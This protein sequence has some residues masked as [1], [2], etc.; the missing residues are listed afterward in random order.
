[1]SQ[2]NVVKQQLE[3]LFENLRKTKAANEQR[4]QRQQVIECDNFEEQRKRYELQQ[5]AITLQ[6]V[7]LAWKRQAD[8][9]LERATILEAAK[10]EEVARGADVVKSKL[11]KVSGKTAVSKRGAFASPN[12]VGAN[13]AMKKVKRVSSV[14]QELQNKEGKRR[15]QK[16]KAEAK[17]KLWKPRPREI[18]VLVD[19]K[20]EEEE[21]N[22][23]E[24][25]KTGRAVLENGVEGLLCEDHGEESDEDEDGTNSCGANKSEVENE[26][27]IKDG[28]GTAMGEYETRNEANGVQSEVN[29]EFEWQTFLE[30]A[31]QMMENEYAKFKWEWKEVE[32]V[33]FEVKKKEIVIE[34][35]KEVKIGEIVMVE[36]SVKR[37]ENPLCE[38]GF[39]I[40]PAE[41][42]K[43]A[44][45]SRVKQSKVEAD[46][47]GMG[48][49]AVAQF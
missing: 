1:M 39:K 19:D 31:K 42:A 26:K 30:E 32:M 37:E 9:A 27:L 15:E 43:M 47:L 35:E 29:A 20:D 13:K 46:D 12:V 5:K 7:S 18:L 23:C 48:T 6:Q 36:K 28:K 24:C 41:D 45:H 33:R 3:V 8:V 49:V 4:W 38:W 11:S 21:N 16:E 34:E 44:W 2:Q 25:D 40:K 10:Q 22:E 14:L 17:E